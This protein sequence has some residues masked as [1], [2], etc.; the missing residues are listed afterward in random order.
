MTDTQKGMTDI[1]KVCVYCGASSDVDDFYKDI[2]RDM[3]VLCAN[4]GWGVVFGGGNIGLMGIL[5]ETALEKGA[6][7]IGII[8]E[9]LQAREICHENLTELHIT[10]SMHERQ[11]MMAKLSDAFIALPGGLGTLAEFFEI[12]T[13]RQL[14]FHDKPIILA[15]VNGYWNSLLKTIDHTADKGFS[16]HED[17]ALFT[18]VED[19]HSIPE[20]LS[21]FEITGNPIKSDKM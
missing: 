13:W 14:K 4:Q 3:A 18:V 17:K 10:Q 21:T 20:V 12:L 1:Q 7:V 19:I 15:N 8:P 2:A 5:A 6:D 11:M 16:R 9:D